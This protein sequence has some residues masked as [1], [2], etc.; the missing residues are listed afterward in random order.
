MSVLGTR[1]ASREKGTSLT[2]EL[3]GSMV[4]EDTDKQKSA[5]FDAVALVG[6][7]DEPAG[8]AYSTFRYDDIEVSAL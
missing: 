7:Q 4:P 1:K 8:G 5:A 2:F 6:E 3:D